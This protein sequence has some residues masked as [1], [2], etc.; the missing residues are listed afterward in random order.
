MKKKKSSAFLLSSNLRVKKLVHLRME[1]I[2]VGFGVFESREK[3][4]PLLI[5]RDKAIA[6]PLVILKIFG[7]TGS[8]QLQFKVSVPGRS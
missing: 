6:N 8:F 4:L 1:G 3:G 2:T 5:S 7:F